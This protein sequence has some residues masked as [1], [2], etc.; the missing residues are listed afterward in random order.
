M[1]SFSGNKNLISS[2]D[3][4]ENPPAVIARN[5]AILREIVMDSRTKS[6]FEKQSFCS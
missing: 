4:N 1:K 2:P 3:G 6:C 5:E